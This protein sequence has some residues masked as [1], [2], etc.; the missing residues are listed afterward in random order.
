MLYKAQT[1]EQVVAEMVDWGDAPVFV[2]GKGRLCIEDR[3]PPMA[4]REFV[5]EAILPGLEHHYGTSPGDLMGLRRRM[6]LEG[7][8]P[9]AHVGIENG[10]LFVISE[11]S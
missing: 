11:P 10:R 9:P 2:D 1:V 8:W 6:I 7:G 5:E 4:G 3:E